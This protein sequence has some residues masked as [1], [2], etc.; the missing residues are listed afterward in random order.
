MTA[1]VQKRWP[2]RWRR[3]ARLMARRTNFFAIVTALAVLAFVTMVTVSVFSIV[4]HAASGEMMPGDLTAWLLF[5]TLVPAMAIVVLVGR[6][7]ALRRAARKEGGGGQLHVRLVF[8]FS[9]I[10]AVPTLIVVLFASWLFQSGVE[11]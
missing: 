1:L 10:S 7:I 8:L 3:R 9:L 6:W 5:G 2:P 11:F 4:D